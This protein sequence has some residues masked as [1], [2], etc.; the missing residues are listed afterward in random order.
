MI[1]GRMIGDL[2]WT[3]SVVF[4]QEPRLQTSEH[5]QDT[6]FGPHVMVE[7]SFGLWWNGERKQ[8][9]VESYGL[10]RFS[11]EFG[12]FGGDPLDEQYFN[13]WSDAVGELASR[14]AQV[15]VESHQ[16]HQQELEAE[17][18]FPD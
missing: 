4:N 8:F 6:A 10:V 14:I 15:R 16:L 7:G 3:L 9:V 18:A 2:A 12:Y 13:S 17:D 11:Y 1:T 5:P